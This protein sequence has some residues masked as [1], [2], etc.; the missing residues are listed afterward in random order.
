MPRRYL[1]LGLMA[2]APLVV[3]LL[4][5]GCSGSSGNAPAKAGFYSG[6]IPGS[7]PHRGGVI[8]FA[9]SPTTFVSTLDPEQFNTS[10][11]ISAQI[12]DQLVELRPMSG[13]PQ[14]AIA[15]SW[16][17]SKDGL[18]YD[19]KLRPGLRFS[20]GMPL[21]ASDVA[22][23]LHRMTTSAN[24]TGQFIFP[25]TFKSITVVSP[26][27]IRF[28]LTKPVTAMIYYLADPAVSI[29]PK[30][31]LTKES[32][33]AFET[34]P[35]GSGPFMVK[36][37]SPG[38]SLELV[39]NPHYWR[40]GQPYLDGLNYKVLADASQRILAVRSGQAQVANAIPYSQIT[41]L[42]HTPGVV[43]SIQHW[44]AV[45]DVYW[46]TSKPPLTDL[47]VRKA[48]AYATPIA[49]II[50][51]VYHGYAEPANT[52]I[53]KMDYWDP[54]VP[55][56]TYNLAKAKQLMRSSAAPHGFSATALVTAGDPDATLTATI[57]QSAWARL[58]V[59]LAIHQI[60][61]TAEGNNLTD[62]NSQIALFETGA[63]LNDTAAPDDAAGLVYD[64]GSGT[65]GLGSF[66]NSPK[67]TRL[68]REASST[69]DQSLRAADYRE[70]QAMSQAQAQMLPLAFVPV[71]YVVSPR[72][73][74]FYALGGGWVDFGQVYLAS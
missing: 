43:M 19:F 7:S 10:I 70:L 50:K 3:A 54:S 18:T 30:N 47:R 39:R 51:A 49:S 40:A 31:V 17:I 59:R 23:T 25:N 57:L 56:Y 36:G 58:G 73:R 20:N 72:V 28:V 61:P 16:T 71:T 62:G 22:F 37:F 35:V 33:S 48:L 11:W 66:L 15:K 65:H 6:G 2:V 44:Y 1:R 21:T 55:Y 74:N 4:S 46:N 9:Q 41:Q 52:I 12:F 13:T 53:P 63:F 32:E 67:M 60:D 29:L 14:P 8:T 68:F 27:E 24:T 38:K 69:Q 64:Y 42:R 5:S 45:D 26:L 34:H